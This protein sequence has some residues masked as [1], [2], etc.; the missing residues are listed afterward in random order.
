MWV[1]IRG[2]AWEGSIGWQVREM[3]ALEVVCAVVSPELAEV[4]DRTDEAGAAGRGHTRQGCEGVL[5]AVWSPEQE[6]IC[7]S[8]NG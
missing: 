4:T 2:P 6:S 3:Q 5:L 8:K 1:Q 7:I